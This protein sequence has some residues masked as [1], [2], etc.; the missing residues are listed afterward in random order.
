ME[1]ELFALFC[2]EYTKHMNKLRIEATSSLAGQKAE[3]SKV[4]RDI[5]RLIDAITDGVA[6]SQ[7][8][9]K[10]L[11]LE[12]RKNELERLIAETDEPPALLHPN[13]AHHYHREIDRLHEA[14]SDEEH[15]HEAVEIIRGLVDR[16]VLHPAP[17]GASETMAIDLE[18]NLAGILIPTAR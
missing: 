11:A 4:T 13:M 2:D 18:G 3:L 7:V 15:R 9:D 6:V 12:A 1:P 14:L 10:M 17:D 16:I 5:D 8:K